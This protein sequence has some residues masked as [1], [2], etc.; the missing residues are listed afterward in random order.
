MLYPCNVADGLELFFG[1]LIPCFCRFVEQVFIMSIDSIAQ[2]VALQIRPKPFH[3]VRLRTVRGHQASPD[4]AT[5]LH[6]SLSL[7]G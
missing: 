2:V 1:Q 6:C 3:G 4:E 7:L 5:S